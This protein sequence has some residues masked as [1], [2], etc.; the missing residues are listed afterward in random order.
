[1]S[2]QTSYTERKQASFILIYR[3]QG[4]TILKLLQNLHVQNNFLTLAPRKRLHVEI[5]NGIHGEI[6]LPEIIFIHLLHH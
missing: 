2:L 6:R 4:E 3:Q 5:Y 1:M